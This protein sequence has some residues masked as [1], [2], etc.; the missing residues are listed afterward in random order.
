MAL[1][2]HDVDTS[3]E[4]QSV[5]SDELWRTWDYKGKLREEATARK[6]KAIVVIVLALVAIGSGLYFL[7][8]R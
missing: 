3:T 6:M 2:E 1:K 7:A 5:I 4:D 8:I